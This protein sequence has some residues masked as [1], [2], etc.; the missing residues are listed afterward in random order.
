MDSRVVVMD[1]VVRRLQ[2][3]CLS[4]RACIAMPSTLIIPVCADPVRHCAIAN[5]LNFMAHMPLNV[6]DVTLIEKCI[7]RVDR[8]VDKRWADA[9][10]SHMYTYSTMDPGLNLVILCYYWLC[11]FSHIGNADPPWL[12]W[13]V[14]SNH[15]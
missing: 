4:P 5:R 15:Q 8:R 1:F 6:Q 12:S 11:I 3:V 10:A 9:K 2:S 13:G 7:A 14:L